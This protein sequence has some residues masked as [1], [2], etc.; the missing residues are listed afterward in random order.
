MSGFDPRNR[1]TIICEGKT[2][3]NYFNGFKKNCI[4]SLSITNVEIGSGDY[5][6]VL[7]KIKNI[8]P[9]GTVARFVVI[10]LD[11]YIKINGEKD[12]FNALLNYCNKENR[13]GNPLFIIAS[14]P[15]FDFFVLNHLKSYNGNNKFEFIKNNFG[16]KNLNDFKNDENIFFRFNIKGD[17]YKTVIS[18]FNKKFP[19]EN[20]YI[21]D[22]KFN[23][24]KANVVFEPENL[25]V[26]TSN[27]IDLFKIL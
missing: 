6:L 24:K 1:I 11:R 9:I 16:Y 27:I 25:N 13:K 10:D 7:R 4:S 18:R 3:F 23:I 14:N 22:K 26:K 8:S 20:R 21:I 17:E 5:S 2:E 12:N 19:V 15:D